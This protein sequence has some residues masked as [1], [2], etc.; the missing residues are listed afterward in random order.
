MRKPILEWDKL[1]FLG[2]CVTKADLK[3]VEEEQLRARLIEVGFE[4]MAQVFCDVY[5][6]R[7]TFTAPPDVIPFYE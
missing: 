3:G 1:D 7:P 2:N 6:G 4:S 5:Y